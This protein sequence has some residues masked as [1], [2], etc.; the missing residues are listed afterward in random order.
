M[1][2]STAFATVEG[3][4]KKL[5]EYICNIKVEGDTVILTDIM[6]TEIKVRGYLK[7][8]DFVKNR[9]IIGE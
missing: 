8:C 1:C 9:I 7:S 5:G 3:Q 2:L 4:E 6:G